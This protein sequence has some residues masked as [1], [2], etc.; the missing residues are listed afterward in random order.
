METTKN[1][2]TPY[3]KNFF[4]KLSMYLDSKIYFY[5]SIQRSDYFPQSSDI[6]ADIFT[7][8]ESSTI[9]KLQNILGVKRY[10]FKKFVYRLHK[11]NK[12]VHG[13]KVKYEDPLNNFSTEIS[14]YNEK[15]K[16]DVLLEHNSKLVLP[17]YISCLL[18]IIKYL[19]YVFGILPK[20]IY[21]YL[22]KIIMNNMVEGSDSEFVV[23]DVPKHD[24]K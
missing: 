3:A 19:Y 15:D 14:I 5:G 23:I 13:I 16:A 1:E 4:N 10:E 20:D 6:D 22:K 2:M 18:I 17:F 7:E 8:N 9:T 21:I 12:I 11:T 24:N